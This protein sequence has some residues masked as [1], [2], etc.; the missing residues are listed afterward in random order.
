MAKKELPK[1]IELDDMTSEDLGLLLSQQWQ[2]LVQAQNNINAI[3][4]TLDK[5]KAK[6]D[7]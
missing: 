6:T 1:N 5:R 4:Q 7:D 2:M 3:T